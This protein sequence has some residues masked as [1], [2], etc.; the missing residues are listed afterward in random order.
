MPFFYLKN[1]RELAPECRFY[2]QDTVDQSSLR[3]PITVTLHYVPVF[4]MNI[5]GLIY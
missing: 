3:I 2:T 5:H 1:E 4:L